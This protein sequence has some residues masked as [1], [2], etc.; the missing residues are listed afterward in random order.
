MSE[1][2]ILFSGQ[3]VRAI[4]DGRKTQTRRIVKPQPA[5]NGKGDRGAE[6]IGGTWFRVWSQPLG[7]STDIHCPYGV[8]GD[9]LWVKETFQPV[10]LASEVTQWRYAATDK[11][12][13]ANWKP[14]IFMPRKASRI[15][16]E[17]TALR[18]E[19]LQAISRYDQISEGCSEP[20]GEYQ[21]LW[22]RING[23]D[24]W[25]ANP[26]VWVVTFKQ[27]FNKS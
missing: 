21:R 14:S 10:Q 24:S 6:H 25:D 13:L 23:K 11:K 20:V 2:P 17:I 18:V 15:T 9:R 8:L 7:N 12:G 5:S 4:L 22:E 19:R 27:V 3:M 26:W 16:L 1:K